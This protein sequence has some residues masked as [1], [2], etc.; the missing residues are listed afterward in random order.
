M[1]R[2]T[3]AG[4]L[5]SSRLRGVGAKRGFVETRLLTRWAEICGPDLAAIARPVKVSYAREGFGATL[6]LACVGARAPELQMQID[7]IRERVNA[8]YGY[9]AISR[10]RLQ[11]EDAAGFAEAQKAFVGAADTEP[12]PAPD[13]AIRRTA[14]ESVA[15]VQSDGLRQALETL[16]THVLTRSRAEREQGDT[17]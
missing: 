4:A 16:G 11:H 5:L 6:V 2:F 7:T 1:M 10:V 15:Q 13:P 8:C 9:N 3:Q 17:R 14:S 12:E